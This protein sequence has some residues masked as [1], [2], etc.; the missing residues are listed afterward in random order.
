M[1]A[2]D[3]DRLV[4]VRHMAELLGLKSCT[5][6]TAVGRRDWSKVPPCLFLGRTIRFSLSTYNQW[7]AARQKETEYA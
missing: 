6:Y 5:V 7:L 2:Q 3:T 1:A 4:D